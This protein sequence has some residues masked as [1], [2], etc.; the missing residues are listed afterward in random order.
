MITQVYRHTGDTGGA[1]FC[2]P[3]SYLP[4]TSNPLPPGYNL[5]FIAQK[6]CGIPQHFQAIYPVLMPWT[7]PKLSYSPSSHLII[8]P[9]I[10][11]LPTDSTTQQKTADQLMHLSEEDCRPVNASIWRKKSHMHETGVL[12]HKKILS[13]QWQISYTKKCYTLCSISPPPHSPSHS[14]EN[15]V[16]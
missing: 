16:K 9:I 14:R 2:F 1:E 7:P 4:I 5:N 10:H 15:Y 11:G 13:I 3:H 6:K 8:I 12:P